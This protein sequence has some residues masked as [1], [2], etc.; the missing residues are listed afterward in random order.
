MAQLGDQIGQEGEERPRYQASPPAACELL[1]QQIATEGGEDEGE[2]DDEI[3]GQ[4]GVAE[5]VIDGSGDKPQG[6][7]VLGI[8][9]DV[10]GGVDDVSLE[11]TGGIGEHGLGIPGDDPG[12]EK[13]VAA[14]P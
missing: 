9:Q 12:I 13:G 6:E 3:V 11:E 8:G 14:P 4:D 1:Y 10:A 2:E 5:Y 7:L